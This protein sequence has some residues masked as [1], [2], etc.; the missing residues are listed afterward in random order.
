MQRLRQASMFA[1]GIGR[2]SL[3]KRCKG[4]EEEFGCLRPAVAVLG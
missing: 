3:Q 2:L 4:K 1:D